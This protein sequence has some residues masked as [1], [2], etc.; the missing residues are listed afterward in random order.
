MT[1]DLSN[2]RQAIAAIAKLALAFSKNMNQEQIDI[3]LTSLRDLSAEQLSTAV[4][5]V[6]SN[7]R[8]FPAIATLRS[9]ALEN[10][11]E[12]SAEEAWGIINERIR[13]QGRAAGARSLS[14][15]SQTAIQACGGWTSLCES[16][17]PTGD[18]IAFVRAYNSVATREKKQ[19]AEAWVH[20]EIA[21]AI[22][23]LSQGANHGNSRKLL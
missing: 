17:N 2:R 7:E 6:M 22:K 23:Q 20:P 16:T 1:D 13:A 3:Y 12:P 8:Y 19:A 15:L 9:A 5:K 10:D 4:N 14:S 21:S 18:R 11:S